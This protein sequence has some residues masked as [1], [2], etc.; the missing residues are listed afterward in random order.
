MKTD[1]TIF[2]DEQNV[3]IQESEQ[4]QADA[5]QQSAKRPAWR[6]AAVGGLTGIVLGAVASHTIQANAAPRDNEPTEE[7]QQTTEETISMDESVQTATPA[8]LP[9]AEVS[10]G[11]S[12]GQAFAAARAEVGAGGVFAWHGNLYSTYTESEWQSMSDE[13]KQAFAA[14]AAPHLA[15][16]SETY[17]HKVET[18][19]ETK[20]ETRTVVE[21]RHERDDNN[22]NDNDDDDDVP[23]VHFLGVESVELDN[24]ETV[25]VGRMT[26]DDVNVA[27]VDTDNDQVFDLRLADYNGN[28]KFEENEASEIADRGITVEEFRYLSEEEAAGR[29]NLASNHEEDLAPGMP[30]YMNDAETGMI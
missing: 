16:A 2:N 25:T 30:D 29:L 13:E 17:V 26:F 22:V 12:F 18:H 6:M 15:H 8:E 20:T 27:L 19:T 5:Q 9:V 24:G 4:Q 3:E 23:D 1:E 14:G 28:G 11:L 10:Q 21:E 7:D